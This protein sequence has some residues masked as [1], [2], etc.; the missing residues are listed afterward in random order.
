MT[1][2]Q[3]KKLKAADVVH[4]KAGYSYFVMLAAEGTTPPIL[5]RCFRMGKA[6]NYQPGFVPAFKKGKRK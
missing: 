1:E 3:M 4:S 2:K 6:A 5:M